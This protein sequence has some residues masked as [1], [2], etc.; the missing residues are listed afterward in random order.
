MNPLRV[1]VVGVGAMGQ[2]HAHIY[3]KEIPQVQLVGV[4]D[5]NPTQGQKIAQ[6]HQTEYFPHYQQLLGK[7]DAVNIVVP[8]ALHYEIALFFLK[9]QIPILLEK[10]IASTVKEAEEIVATAKTHQTLLQIGHLERFNPVFK[11]IQK[12]KIQPAYIESH[13]IAQFTPRVKDVGVILDLMIHDID[14]VLQLTRS[15]LK[16][17]LAVGVNLMGDH[18]DIANARL[19]FENGCV[20]SLTASRIAMKR[21]RKIRVFAKDAYIIL[22]YDT[23]TGQIIQKDPQITGK[24]LLEHNITNIAD[25]NERTLEL[26]GNFIHVDNFSLSHEERPLQQELRSFI[27]CILEKK[28]PEVTGEDGLIALKT[29]MEICAQVEKFKKNHI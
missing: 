19:E 4:C 3:H 7:V 23:H 11:R 28:A 2:L 25:L 14:I 10:P 17:I 16:N 20:A 18:E 15:P 27:S 8:T 1:A 29:G 21:E 6:L 13:R 5:V 26:V 12:E 24:W 22:N 9:N